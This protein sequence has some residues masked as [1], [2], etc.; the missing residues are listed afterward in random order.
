M[1]NGGI[2]N[3]NNENFVFFFAFFAFTMWIV[4]KTLDNM[5]V[6]MPQ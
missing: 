6:N 1:R 3:K 4:G 5:V 2:N